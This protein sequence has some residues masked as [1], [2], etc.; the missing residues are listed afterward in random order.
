M[1]FSADEDDNG[2]MAD[3]LPEPSPTFRDQLW[4]VGNSICI[5]VCCQAGTVE[6]VDVGSG[7]KRRELSLSMSWRLPISVFSRERVEAD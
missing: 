7:P 6:V 3:A 1:M 4:G 5:Q 2:A